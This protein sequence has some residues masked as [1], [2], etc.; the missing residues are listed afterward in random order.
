MTIVS[1]VTNFCDSN[2]KVGWILLGILAFL[3]L[4]YIFMPCVFDCF[5]IENICGLFKWLWGWLQT[6]YNEVF[7]SDCVTGCGDCGATESGEC[8]CEGNSG[9][10]G[11]GNSGSGGFGGSVRG[12]GN[13]VVNL[14]AVNVT[15]NG[16]G[17]DPN[18]APLP[19][20]II[21]PISVPAIYPSGSGGGCGGGSYNSGGGCQKNSCVTDSVS[22]CGKNYAI[23]YMPG[24]IRVYD[25][26]GN[27][28]QTIT[29]NLDILRSIRYENDKFVVEDANSHEFAGVIVNGAINFTAYP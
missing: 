21:P 2:S 20:I 5:S 22:V 18:P 12:Q 16:S 15:V 17:Q 4:I 9:C 27:I 24:Q 19:P 29:H 13:I 25:S 1:E 14:P 3:F 6:L 26:L 23:T 7:G 10:D 8:G 11:T 28:I